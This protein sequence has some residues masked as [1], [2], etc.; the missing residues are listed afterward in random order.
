MSYVNNFTVD[1]VFDLIK[2]GAMP[3]EDF[4]DWVQHALE[5]ASENGYDAGFSNTKDTDCF[6]IVP[7]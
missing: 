7:A 4:K 3:R 6:G 1:V 2:M 5:V